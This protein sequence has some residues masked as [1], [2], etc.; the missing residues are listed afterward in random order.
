M[1]R[2]EKV[3]SGFDQKLTQEASKKLDLLCFVWD[4]IAIQ[5]AY[6]V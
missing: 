6:S 1:S 2:L 4:G 5:D 3:T